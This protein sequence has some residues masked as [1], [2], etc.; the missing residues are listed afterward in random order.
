MWFEVLLGKIYIC[1]ICS[2]LTVYKYKNIYKMDF[3]YLKGWSV[4]M[5]C[6]WAI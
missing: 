1:L 3:Q 2:S 4:S 5:K 6:V